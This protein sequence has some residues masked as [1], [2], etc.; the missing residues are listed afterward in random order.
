MRN[1]FGR[2]GLAFATGALITGLAGFGLARSGQP[3]E[4]M[5]PEQMMEMMKQA[6]APDEHHKAL[7]P[8]VGTWNV[9]SKFWMNPDE[10]MVST[11]KSVNEWILGERFVSTHY[12]GELMD[13]DFEG[14][15]ALGY[16]KETGEYESVWLDNF[17]TGFLV[18]KG[19]PG[20]DLKTIAVEGEYTSAMGTAS[21]KIVTKIISN[22]KHVTEF[23]EPR[24][25]NGEMIRT[26]ELTY[27]R[28]Q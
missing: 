1:S 13:M 10:P 25:E 2:Y 11:G 5:S 9:E 14:Y 24:G 6:A 16:H 27:T 17:G 22:D 26:G 23:W 21:M 28:A 12:T 15:G 19:K 7:E 4:E 8:L 18:Q 20:T 3:E